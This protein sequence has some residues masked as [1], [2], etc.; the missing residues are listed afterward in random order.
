[1]A[2]DASEGRP[3][4]A[5]LRAYRLAA[6][7]SQEELAERA[8]LG[9]RTISDLE[10]GVSTAPYRGTVELL[11]DALALAPAERETFAAT[12]RGQARQ[13]AATGAAAS[14]VPP[15][16][17]P[18]E[19]RAFLIADVRG[20]TRFTREQGD[21]AAARLAARFAAL[22]SE[23]VA[24]GGGAVIEVRGD[25]ALAVFASP[26]QAL[27]TAVALHE[28]FAEEG[29][30]DPSLP[31]QVGIGLDA[32][33]AVP[34]QGGYRGGALNLAAR[35]GALAGPGQALASAEI[36]HLAGTVQGLVFVDRG[37]VYLKGLAE[38][39][40]VVQVARE[41]TLPDS[42]PPLEAPAPATHLP[43]PLTSFVGR[44]P[45]RA[46]VQELLECAPLVVLT[47][48][49]GVGKTRLALQVAQELHDRY[50]DGVWLVELAPL[51]DPSLVGQTVAL[52]LGLIE[53]PDRPLAAAL[54]E[55]LGPKRLLL[56]LDNCE[57]LLTAAAT[58]AADL[59]RACPQLRILATSRQALGVP[60]EVAYRVPSLAVP[61]PD[62]V[63]IAQEMQEGEAVRLFV[64]R[65]R[66]RR[67]DFALTEENARAV[68]AIC[69]RLD[70]VPLAIELAAARVSVL[71]VQQI[72]GRLEDR[73][74]LLIGGSTTTPPRQRT[75]QATLDWSYDLLSGEERTVLQRLAVFA[76][77]CTLEAA[78]AVLGAG[79]AIEPW[80]VLDVLDG[81]VNQS[82]LGMEEQGGEA[83]Y[84]LLE[85]VRQYAHERLSAAGGVERSSRDHATWYA[86]FAQRAEPG[87]L[88]AEQLGWLDRLEAERDNLR[89]AL[90]WSAPQAARDPE[91][92]ERGLLLAAALWRF[93]EL[94]GPLRAGRRWLEQALAAA[95]HADPAPRARALSA[96]GHL[97]VLQ[98]DVGTAGAALD[99]A[100]ALWRDLPESMERRR[101][102]ATTLL[103]LGAAALARAEYDT[104]SARFGDSLSLWQALGEAWGMAG[105]LEGLGSVAQKRLPIEG[106]AV[107][108]R[109]AALERAA[110]RFGESLT[111]R[112][113]IGDAWGVSRA[114]HKLGTVAQQQGEEREE[115]AGATAWFERALALA[116]E[117][118]D[119]QGMGAALL[120]LGM[121]ALLQG[122][123]VAAEERLG[124][125]LTLC[126][127]VGATA[128]SAEVVT[129]L[130]NAACLRAD[131]EIA[132]AHAEEAEAVFARLGWE[133]ERAWLTN[134]RGYVAVAQGRFAEGAS[135]AEESLR[136]AYK[137][138]QLFYAVWEH[139]VLG[140]AR[141]G[142]G[143][144][145]EA[146]AQYRRSLALLGGLPI[147]SVRAIVSWNLAGLAQVAAARGQWAL[148]ARLLGARTG[149][150]QG[151]ARRFV[152]PLERGQVE[153]ADRVAR[154]AL[155]EES[156]AAAFA[157]GCRL[158][159][160]EALAC[161]LGSS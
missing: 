72:L 133:P 104:A 90:V 153:E 26:R 63:A 135:L 92:A 1:M 155:G 67:T 152:Y 60:G 125:A 27:G 150:E 71:P 44:V 141:F 117:L 109:G 22:A 81:L 30:R 157:A 136:I 73:F 38:A 130:A 101:G 96:L 151:V 102:E 2:I 138:G 139:P 110:A 140:C 69:A 131:W 49:G 85:T 148:A 20:Y 129:W 45:E 76:G 97:A 126:R 137:H 105:A 159:R 36:V 25:E 18:S 115:Y 51:A 123:G 142:Q 43:A 21:E 111:L 41:G 106:L 59:L 158:D 53:Q 66:A 114:Y 68:A 33:E 19:V 55:F 54:V 112:Q 75:L 134:T 88:G 15:A 87:L 143:D 10:R 57:H 5:L 37:P 127:Q 122:D 161:A 32:G 128:R 154:A 107:H 9:R 80:A 99:A 91:A 113:Q 16:G 156:V 58:L 98:G 132:A 52:A 100:L 108:D 149:A 116:R 79:G 7:L 145:D 89:A 147:L 23:V 46:E 62:R 14:G 78:E 4:G 24:A 103:D 48:T 12:A 74:H 84:Y 56:L 40:L 29:E 124:A 144:L 11:A 35:L 50:P 86:Q 34:V 70:G 93:W 95:Q 64:E 160:E 47:G 6:G 28:R 65:A 61:D 120:N 121:V 17:A 13:P 83:R 39:V 42:L 77:G 8:R 146:V 119:W 94:R 118:R 3:F 31:L 82:L